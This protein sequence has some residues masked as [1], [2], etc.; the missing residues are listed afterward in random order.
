MSDLLEEASARLSDCGN[1]RYQLTRKW[2]DGPIACFL[3]LN[4]STADANQDDQTIRKCRGFARREGCGGFIVAN[5]FAFRA[6]DPKHLLT[7][8]DPIDPEND[9]MTRDAIRCATGTGGP[10]IAAWGAHKM[11]EKR[12]KL[13]ATWAEGIQC[14]GLTKAGH[15]RHPL[16]RKGDAPLI[17]LPP[18]DQH[19]EAGT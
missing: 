18:A 11:V 6:T 16:Y 19:K 9:V 3:M 1:Y 4:P 15:P 5:L 17:P 13:V 12:A 7:A 14:L 8:A 10:I 2:G